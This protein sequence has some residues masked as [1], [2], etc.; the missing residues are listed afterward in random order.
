MYNQKS[1]LR[2]LLIIIL[3]LIII[4]AVVISIS[5]FTFKKEYD[6]PTSLQALLPRFRLIDVGLAGDGTDADSD[7]INDQQ[8]ILIGAKKQLASPA[9]N[10]FSEGVDEPNYYS[11]GDPPPEF[12]LCTDIIA[13]AFKEAGFDLMQLV[14][15]DITANFYAYP[16]QKIWGQRYPDANIDY[17]RIQ[18]LE[19]FFIRNAEELILTFKPEDLKN[20]EQWMPGHIVFF[21]MDKDGHTDNVGII[22]DFTTR[23]G[24]PKVIYNYIDPGYTAEADILG[25]A[26]ITGHYRYPGRILNNTGTSVEE[27]GNAEE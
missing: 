8:D 12:A 16:L 20:L 15:D 19:V 22:S 17:R 27:T 21:D 11:G 6:P 4:L 2:T 7:G 23:K 26:V 3:I 10:I 1:N 5:Q 9:V 14:N 24:V 25:Q 18:N 13:R